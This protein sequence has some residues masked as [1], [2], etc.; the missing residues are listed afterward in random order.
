MNGHLRRCRCASGAHVRHSTLRSSE[1]GAQERARRIFTRADCVGPVRLASGAFLNRLRPICRRITTNGRTGYGV[2]LSGRPNKTRSSP[3]QPRCAHGGPPGG[4]GRRDC[5]HW[6]R[7]RG[8]YLCFVMGHCGTDVFRY[9]SRMSCRASIPTSSGD[10]VSWL[11]AP[12]SASSC[13]RGESGRDG[14]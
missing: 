3:G 14:R 10:P 8:D 7:S 12:G 4:A 6:T 2:W 1:Q 13:W 5:R 9:P 11:R